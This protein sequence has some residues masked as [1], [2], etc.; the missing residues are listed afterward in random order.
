MNTPPVPHITVFLSRATNVPE[1]ER[2]AEAFPWQRVH[3]SLND[4]AETVLE[5]LC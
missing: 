4:A 1:E 3:S 5:K 2:A